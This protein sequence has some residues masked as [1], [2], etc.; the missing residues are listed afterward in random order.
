MESTCKTS[1]L[2]P[3]GSDQ[4]LYWVNYGFLDSYFTTHSESLGNHK[5]SG[6]I[7]GVQGDPASCGSPVYLDKVWKS[8]SSLFSC[9][10]P[11]AIVNLF[12]AC[13]QPGRRSGMASFIKLTWRG[14]GKD[15]SLLVTSL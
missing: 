5:S 10:C 14:A 13:I 15:L 4:Q 12:T 7:P 11:V 8:L 9:M 3:L 1:S 2:T 6:L